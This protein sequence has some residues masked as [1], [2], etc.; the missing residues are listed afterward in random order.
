[1]SA[2]TIIELED[3]TQDAL[4]GTG[5]QQTWAG[6]EATLSQTLLHEIGHALGLADNADPNSV[7]NYDLTS[8]SQQLDSTD[9][10]AIQALY[11]S[12]SGGTSNARL[13]ALIQAMAGYA[14][15]GA[16][17]TALPVTTDPANQTRYLAAAHH[18]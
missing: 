14:P 6:T 13:E 17:Q 8:S 4:T 11:G 1:M 5:G 10:Q 16:A 9:V 7:M 18:N 3:P 2:G 12:P 15:S